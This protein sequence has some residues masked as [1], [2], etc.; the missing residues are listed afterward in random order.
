MGSESRF[1]IERGEK[2]DPSP[3]LSI[4]GVFYE[5]FSECEVTKVSFS[6]LNS[7]LGHIGVILGGWSLRAHTAAGGGVRGFYMGFLGQ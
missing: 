2:G 6:H 3:P 1:G 7:H 5:A 4:H